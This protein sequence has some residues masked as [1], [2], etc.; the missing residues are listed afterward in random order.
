MY[1]YTHK[2]ST[3]SS[4]IKDLQDFPKFTTLLN[5]LNPNSHK[6]Q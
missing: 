3:L 5:V 2:T 4:C 1:A 6:P